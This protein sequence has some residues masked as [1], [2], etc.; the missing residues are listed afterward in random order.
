MPKNAQV[1]LKLLYC[2]YLLG[3]VYIWFSL[4]QLTAEL[5]DLSQ[6][7]KKNLLLQAEQIHQMVTLFTQND[8]LGIR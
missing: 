8:F 5:C 1:T 2:A 3:M 4:L 6:A 7:E